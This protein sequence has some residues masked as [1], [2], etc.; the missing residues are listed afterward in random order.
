MDLSK[1][2]LRERLRQGFPA[3]CSI[4]S[5]VGAHPPLWPVRHDKKLR[6]ALLLLLPLPDLEDHPYSPSRWD[7][8]LRGEL[9]TLL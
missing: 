2:S 7:D 1:S 6:H 5:R 4:R 8:V 9:G 3:Q